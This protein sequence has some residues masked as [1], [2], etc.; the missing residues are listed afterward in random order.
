MAKYFG[1]EYSDTNKLDHYVSVLQFMMLAYSR[2]YLMLTMINE[3]EISQVY[4]AISSL[5]DNLNPA[6]SVNVSQLIPIPSK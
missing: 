2:I 3:E 5:K 6:Q 4:R 1:L